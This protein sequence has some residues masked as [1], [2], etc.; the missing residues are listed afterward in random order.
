MPSQ[1]PDAA[2][3]DPELHHAASMPPLD[4]A[5]QPVSRSMP[6][7]SLSPA[8]EDPHIQ[9][10]PQGAQDLPSL[11]TNQCPSSA[12]KASHAATQSHAHGQP[13][14]SIPDDSTQ[15]ASADGVGSA[16]VSSTHSPQQAGQGLQLSSGQQEGSS[17]SRGAI[18]AAVHGDA[19]SGC[20]G[21]E[22]AA[23]ARSAPEGGEDHPKQ[24][25]PG[26]PGASTGQDT[27][28]SHL[29]QDAGTAPQTDAQ[30]HSPAPASLAPLLLLADEPE[31][32]H[33]PAV[34]PAAPAQGSDAGPAA[35]SIP[36]S[37]PSQAPDS[38]ASSLPSWCRPAESADT[39]VSPAQP[40]SHVPLPA[41]SAPADPSR[42]S[43]MP[44]DASEGS[45]AAPRHSLLHPF[46]GSCGP[47][48]VPPAPVPLMIWTA[49]P[50]AEDQSDKEPEVH[51]WSFAA[52]DLSDSGS[53]CPSAAFGSPSPASSASRQD[54]APVP[55]WP[56][57]MFAV[58][59]IIH[60]SAAHA[61]ESSAQAAARSAASAMSQHAHHHKSKAR[62]AGASHRAADDAA[63]GHVLDLSFERLPSLETAL[64]G[65]HASK[66]LL[67]GNLLTTL[68]GKLQHPHGLRETPRVLPLPSQHLSVS[69]SI[70]MCSAI[71]MGAYSGCI[72]LNRVAPESWSHW[73]RPGAMYAAA[74]A[75]CGRQPA[76]G[77][78]S[79]MPAPTSQ[80][81]NLHSCL[82]SYLHAAHPPWVSSIQGVCCIVCMH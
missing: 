62:E 3:S 69:R 15:A 38:V 63:D 9:L 79:H 50:A 27:A 72:D 43:T 20:L 8:I 58:D 55:C 31:A 80:V 73:C 4:A 30:A 81:R 44:D 22:P 82:L 1:Q 65:K 45:A 37:M 28:E 18:S 34:Q 75:A 29:Q 33:N 5:D 13:R 49:A 19:A 64:Q 32:A 77:H 12:G 17:S 61:A 57:P 68:S 26:L 21:P 41:A 78:S 42:L 10:C 7:G 24:L 66:L 46:P 70:L 2:D 25:Q 14:P 56:Q 23:Q 11:T 59:G 40:C 36:Q 76:G 16:P 74:G 47:A 48:Q 35:S 67:K 54:S 71:C 39:R 60:A 6:A 53:A 51:R 52:A